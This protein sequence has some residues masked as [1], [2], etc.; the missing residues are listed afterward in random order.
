MSAGEPYRE[1]LLSLP[2]FLTGQAIADDQ[3]LEQALDLTGYFLNA[4]V[5]HPLNRG[6]PGARTRFVDRYRK[7]TTISGIPETTNSVD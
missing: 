2:P 3:Q 5:F 4:C 1:K 7:L 6:E